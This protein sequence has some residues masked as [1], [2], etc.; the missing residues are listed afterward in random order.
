MRRLARREFLGLIGLGAS[1]IAGLNGCG[2][3]PFSSKGTQTS[4]SRGAF[5]PDVELQL[6]AT[7]TLASILPG[8]LTQ[9]WKYVGEVLKGDSDSLQ[10]I[11][12]SYL[13]PIIRAKRGQKLRIHLNNALPEPTI[14]HW[15]TGD[16]PVCSWF[17][18]TKKRQR[19][20]RA[21]SLMCRWS[22]RI[23]RSTGQINSSM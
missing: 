7:E 13:G 11:P 20:C 21:V 12:N 18:T 10:T 16:S 2:S 3:G 17:R 1:T 8:G 9:V 19:I 22:S 5:V 15:Y 6:T 23:A 14:V 4:Q